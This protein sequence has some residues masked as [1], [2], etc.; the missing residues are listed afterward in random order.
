M[1]LYSSMEVFGIGFLMS[2]LYLMLLFG[3]YRWAK[4]KPLKI[5]LTAIFVL[6]FLSIILFCLNG[7]VRFQDKY[8][9]LLNVYS[10]WIMSAFT[11]AV[12][13]AVLLFVLF[14]RSFKA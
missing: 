4:I 8:Q 2:A 14:K 5:L 7:L 13:L 3:V 12:L 6:P 1:K 11:F 9:G 10:I